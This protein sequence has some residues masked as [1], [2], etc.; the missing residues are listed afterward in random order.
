MSSKWHR[1]IQ[2]LVV[3]SAM[4]AGL[5]SATYYAAFTFYFA[6]ELGE[7]WCVLAG[8]PL[9]APWRI[10]FWDF[11]YGVHAPET[12]RT[13][14]YFTYGGTLLGILGACISSAL[15]GAGQKQATTF[16]SAHWATSKDIKASGLMDGKGVVLGK[17]ADGTYLRHDGPEHVI[18]IAPT[19]SGKGVGIVIPTLLSTSS[20]VLVYDPKA[21]NWKYTAGYRSSFSRTICFGPGEPNSAHFNPLLEV[22]R[23]D[24]EV[25]DVQNIADMIVDP[26]GKGMSDHWAKTGHSLL[27]GTILHVLYDEKNKTLAGV[28]NFL[29]NPDHTIVQTLEAMM[30]AKHTD[31][32]THAVVAAAARDM[33]NK[34]ENERSGVLSTAM[35]F[36]SLYRDPIVARNTA[37]SDFRIMDLV[38]STNPVSL[39]LVIPPSDIN[40]LRPL[41]RLMVN[42]IC[43]RLTEELNPTANKH[44]LL[45]LLDEFP[46]LG[47]LDFFETALGL[48][49]G[50][51]IKAMLISQSSNQLD[52]TYG[53]KNSILDNTHVRVFYAPNTIETAE[54]V[55]RMLGQKTEV[56]QQM[57]YAGHRLSP[58]LEHMSVSDHE[59]ARALMT[60]G[61]VMELPHTD[62]L[63][64]VAGQPPIRAK[65][66][67][68]HDEAHFKSRLLPAPR[69][70]DSKFS[71]PAIHGTWPTAKPKD[72]PGSQIPPPGPTSPDEPV[73]ENMK[74][75][76]V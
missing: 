25:R 28:A 12:F 31:D 24:L 41:F 39:Y 4:L 30:K 68:Y 45:L 18:V 52:K 22:R 54:A 3:I 61:E 57:N 13:A 14:S 51:G 53:P 56:H 26:E 20:S 27:V 44:R 19:R 59:S 23:G 50:Y 48:I 75:L 62:E 38:Q 6:P 74:Q 34:S 64:F 73:K 66:I 15:R 17:T 37:D 55:S 16:G 47:R 58:F 8:Y 49:A 65:K 70:E 7:P 32:R 69:P 2:L 10:L 1:V 67:R 76:P 21:E 33:L 11:Q 43:R 35:S 29:S 40:R 46:A 72:G 36:L 63:I 60:P 9:Y 42:Q 71:G 5:W